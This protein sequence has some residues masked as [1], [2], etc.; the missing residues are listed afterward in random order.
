MDVVKGWE[1]YGLCYFMFGDSVYRYV[2][3][4]SGIVCG[5]GASK[6]LTLFLPKEAKDEML[7]G[8][9][10]DSCLGRCTR[11]SEGYQWRGIVVD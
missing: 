9:G 1:E 5:A 4:C 10:F 6:R 2:M 11:S 3:I 8:R 7:W